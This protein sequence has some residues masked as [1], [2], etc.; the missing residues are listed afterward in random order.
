M[1]ISKTIWLPVLLI[2]AFLVAGIFAYQWWQ[3]KEKVII[4][5]DKTE[6][7]QGETIE[8]TVRNGLD[9]PI[10]YVDFT[11]QD[12]R[13][14]DIEKFEGD[15]WENLGFRLPVKEY[16]K[17]VCYIKLYERP[18][19]HVVELK[20][21]SEFSREWNQKIC[22][23]EITKEQPFEPIF[24][25]K[26]RY[27]FV[28]EYGLETTKLPEPEKEPWKRPVD[29]ADVKVIYSNEFVIKGD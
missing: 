28:F 18:I 26:G 21:N 23:L 13:F 20:S 17:E 7:E 24:I 27:R 8:I 9:I 12:L 6:Y 3:A 10:W 15:K 29:L 14:W 19:G 25:E 2:V 1:N 5:T 16:G 4:T 11:Q 22:L